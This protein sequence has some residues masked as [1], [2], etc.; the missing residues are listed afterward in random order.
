MI[1]VSHGGIDHADEY[2]LSWE[3]GITALQNPHP[4]PDI[5]RFNLVADIHDGYRLLKLAEY[6]A[7]HHADE[8]IAFAKIGQQG[9]AGK[10]HLKAGPD[11]TMIGVIIQHPMVF[12]KFAM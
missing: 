3:I 6:D 10:I 4:L 8:A 11:K 5:L 2:S 9:N 7:F 1:R 12:C